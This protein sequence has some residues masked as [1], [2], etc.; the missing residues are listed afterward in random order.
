M[1]SVATRDQ[2]SSGAGIE[3][4]GTFATDVVVGG[5]AVSGVIRAW[6][7]GASGGV[8]GGVA[9]VPHATRMT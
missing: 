7:I 5:G 4:A 9:G 6:G 3:A 8:A 1:K 2:M